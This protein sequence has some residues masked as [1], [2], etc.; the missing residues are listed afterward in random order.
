M[1]LITQ[2]R[3]DILAHWNRSV[4]KNAL[5]D[6]NKNL[7]ITMAVEEMVA[8]QAVEGRSSQTTN[9][10]SLKLSLDVADEIEEYCEI[11]QLPFDDCHFEWA[12]QLRASA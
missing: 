1:L 8:A 11:H 6:D 2:L 3:S 4:L 5:S 9:T 10:G 12:R 7:L